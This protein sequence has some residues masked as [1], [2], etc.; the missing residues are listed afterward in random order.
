MKYAQDEYELTAEE[1]AKIRRR[2]VLFQQVTKSRKSIQNVLVS[3]YGMR[4][5]CHSGIIHREVTL[6]DLFR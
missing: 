3:T 5:S 6:S 1:A 4:R 2:G